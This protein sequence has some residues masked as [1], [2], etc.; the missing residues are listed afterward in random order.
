M[1]LIEWTISET[2]MSLCRVLYRAEL[3]A[4]YRHNVHDLH[5][6]QTGHVFT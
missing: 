6:Y 3:H 2:C 5:H 1:V 4:I